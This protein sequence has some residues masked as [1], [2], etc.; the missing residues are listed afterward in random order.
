MLT[1]ASSP[2]NYRLVSS[3]TRSWVQAPRLGTTAGRIDV[4]NCAL[5]LRSWIVNSSRCPPGR[6]YALPNER[7]GRCYVFDVQ[8]MCIIGAVEERP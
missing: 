6:L 2:R 3:V 8:P 5:I 4:T 1:N 7:R